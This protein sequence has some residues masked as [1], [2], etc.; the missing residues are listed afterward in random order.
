MTPGRSARAAVA[1]EA[2]ALLLAAPVPSGAAETGGNAAVA[3]GRALVEAQCSPCHATGPTGASPA[4]GAPAFRELKQRYPVDDLAEGL[5]E[6][7]TVG[8]P[9]IPEF[10]FAPEEIEDILAYLRTL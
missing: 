4:E 8:H 10:A 9:Q 1:I 5:A 7:L 2:A 3:R 6:G